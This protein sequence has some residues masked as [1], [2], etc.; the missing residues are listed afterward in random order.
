LKRRTDAIAARAF[1]A[2]QQS[3]ILYSQLVA[4]V[5]KPMEGLSDP[6]EHV[7]VSSLDLIKCGLTDDIVVKSLVE[8]HKV[9]KQVAAHRWS[10]IRSTRNVL[11]WVGAGTGPNAE[12]AAER[13]DKEPA[14][15]SGTAPAVRKVEKG[16]K[17][18]KRTAAEVADADAQVYMRPY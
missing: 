3:T 16:S 13:A 7:C 12:R 10:A 6:L 18:H 5:L 11:H 17:K 2:S 4:A 9:M 14:A 8:L 15:V 1:K